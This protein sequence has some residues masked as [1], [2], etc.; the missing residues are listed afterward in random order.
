MAA[1]GGTTN[2]K[3]VDGGNRLI[4]AGIAF[5]VVTMA[6]CGL[7]VLVYVFRYRKARSSRSEINEKSS[8]ES[9][10]EQGVRLGT[11]KLFGWGIVLA[12]TTV[13]IRCI[14]RLPE[15]AGGWGNALMRNETEFLLLD[16]M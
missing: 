2:K 16:G 8:Y 3:L 6:V 5:Q 10:K 13:L 12:Y 14:Y 15:M 11:V 4:V 9:D 1:A 7:F